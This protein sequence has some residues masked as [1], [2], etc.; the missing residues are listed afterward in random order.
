MKTVSQSTLGLVVLI[1]GV[2]SSAAEYDEMAKEVGAC[3]EDACDNVI[4][5]SWLANFR[6][7]L[8]EALNAKFGSICAWNFREETTPKGAVK[9]VYDKETSYVA[10]LKEALTK[11]LSGEQAA[12]D[13]MQEVA[14]EVAARYP[15]TLERVRTGGKIS[16]E[17]LAA[18]DGIIAQIEEA[19]GDYTKFMENVKA[20]LTAYVFAIDEST[21]NPTREAVALAIRGIQEQAVRAAKEQ[22]LVA[23]S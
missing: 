14:T 18:A 1:A 9:K 21:G 10:Q 4:Y 15:F 2:P 13:A 11:Q 17:H 23:L 16:A 6:P 3:V 5:R 20:K 22:A 12:L 8:A 7:K 19:G